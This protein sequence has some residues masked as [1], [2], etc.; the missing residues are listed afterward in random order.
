MVSPYIVDVSPLS[1]SI[2]LSDKDNIEIIFNEMIN[3]NSIKSSIETYPE[4]EIKINWEGEG[5][6]EIGINE[7]NGK[8]IVA[9]D[10]KYFRP[11]EVDLLIGD[12]SKAE[13]ELGWKAK[14]SF[15]E[16]VRKMTNSDWEKVKRRGY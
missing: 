1:G 6:N 13:K 4:L 9:I 8:T 3:P 15:S 10:E 5:V 16:L 14:T 2:N 11:T 12:P 7:K